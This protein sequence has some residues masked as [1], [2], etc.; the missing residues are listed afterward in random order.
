MNLNKLAS[1]IQ[2]NIVSGLSGLSVNQNFTIEQIEDAI[3]NERMLII[4]EYMAKNIIPKKDLVLAVRC[5]EVDCQNVSKCCGR[6]FGVKTQHTEIPQIFNDYGSDSVD[7]LGSDNTLEGFVVYTDNSFRRH[8][9]RRRGADKPYA[10]IDTTPNSNGFNDVFIFNAPMLKVITF[11]GIFKDPRQLE[12]Y[13]CCSPDEYDNYSFIQADI[14][15]RVTANFLRHYR[16]FAAP[17]MPNTQQP[18]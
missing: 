14:E 1:A 3:I 9:N 7:F 17:Y 2:N 18:K 6:E 4:K 10:W 8:K 5:L 16:Q 15:K 11:R 13:G 12:R